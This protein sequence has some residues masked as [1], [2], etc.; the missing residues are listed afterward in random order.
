MKTCFLLQNMLKEEGLNMNV[1]D[2]VIAVTGGAG[3][4]GSAIVRTLCEKDA[5]VWI[6]D[7]RGDAGE[8][9][10]A[11]FR[12]EGWKVY[13][14]QMDVGVEAD[15]KRAI[16][17][18]FAQCG[19][20]DSVVN[21]AAINIRKSVL[22]MNQEEWSHM[23]DVN[24][25]SIFLSCKYAIP[26]MKEQASGG[27]IIN[28]SSVCGLIGHMYTTEAYTASK[29]AVTLLTRA[30][31]ARYGHLNIRS[32]SI[33]PCTVDTPFVAAV[34]ADPVRKQQRIDEVPL[35]R[36]GTVEDVANAVLYL[37]SEEGS[38]INGCALTVD[39]G[40]TCY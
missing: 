8:E 40:T 1:K 37:A 26:I 12:A 9:K 23:M 2:K 22:E 33:H 6:L 18:I 17:V 19:R 35:G 38:F 25:G 7:I 28:I 30:V 4:I 32:N 36:L 27:T 24:T 3:G 5:I 10:A 20:L 11:A 21:L 15:W 13:S 14:V 29:G 34:M 39:G 16:D 31:A